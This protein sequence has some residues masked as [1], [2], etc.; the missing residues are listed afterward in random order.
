VPS[1]RYA[2]LKYPEASVNVVATS[3][4]ELSYKYTA[5]HESNISVPLPYALDVFVSRY[6]YPSI[7]FGSFGKSVVYTVLLTD[8]IILS[9]IV[10]TELLITS[11]RT[12][13]IFFTFN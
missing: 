4:P 10:A 8:W 11:P 1:T 3:A 7:L 12:L 9:A 5:T 2:K 6:T 13:V